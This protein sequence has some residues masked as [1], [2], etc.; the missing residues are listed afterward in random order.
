MGRYVRCP[1]QFVTFDAVWSELAP[2]F[3]PTFAPQNQG[4]ALLGSVAE[5]LARIGFTIGLATREPAAFCASGSD[6]PRR[7]Q[8]SQVANV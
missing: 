6:N 1:A 3:Y 7:P 2:K 5:H 8:Q 4:P